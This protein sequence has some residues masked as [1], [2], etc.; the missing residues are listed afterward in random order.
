MFPHWDVLSGAPVVFA[1]EAKSHTTPLANHF[2]PSPPPIIFFKLHGTVQILCTCLPFSLN[3]I[4][5]SPK[6]G[7]LASSRQLRSIRKGWGFPWGKPGT[8]RV[9]E[10]SR[11]LLC[12]EEA[13]SARLR[14]TVGKSRK[15]K[16]PLS[17]WGERPGSTEGTAQRAAKAKEVSWGGKCASG[18][19][20]GLWGLCEWGFVAVLSFFFNQKHLEPPHLIL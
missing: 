17:L 7:W 14:A 6:R 9:V 12:C 19:K 3:F 11:M 15:Q 8:G 5:C 13:L 18:R 2:N 16:W 4:V 10:H 1:G 20:A